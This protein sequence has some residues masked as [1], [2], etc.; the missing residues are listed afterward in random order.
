MPGV[1]NT[2][3]PSGSWINRRRWQVRRWQGG[4]GAPHVPLSVELLEP[5]FQGASFRFSIAPKLVAPP[6]HL[7]GASLRAASLAPS[8]EP[9]VP[10]LAILLHL[11]SGSWR[12]C[13]GAAIAFLSPDTDKFA[14]FH[15]MTI[16]NVKLVA[17]VCLAKVAHARRVAIPRARVLVRF[18]SKM[19][20]EGTH[21][22]NFGSKSG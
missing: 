20:N 1:R 6:V 7:R 13:G 15:G 22:S 21:R 16:V 19:K 14:F 9:L 2:V 17:Q 8:A 4:A 3:P 5:I 10:E 18:C 11:R 12:R